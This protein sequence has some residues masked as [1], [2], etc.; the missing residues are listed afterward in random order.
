M[1]SIVFI[2]TA[3]MLLSACQHGPN[4]EYKQLLPRVIDMNLGRAIASAPA[5]RTTP[6]DGSVNASQTSRDRGNPSE[7]DLK[8]QGWGQCENTD[9]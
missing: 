2:A 4:G 9:G 1:K 5:A 7:R 3:V 8:C 6:V